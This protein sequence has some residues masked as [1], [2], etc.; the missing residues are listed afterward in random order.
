MRVDAYTKAVLTIIAACLLWM[1][2]TG[3]T[4]T[5]VAAQALRDREPQEV[6]LIGSRAPVPV[7]TPP[8][9][10]LVVRPG[11]EWYQEPLLVDAPRPLP[12]R[13]TGVERQGGRWDPLDVNVKEQP[14]KAAPGHRP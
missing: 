2:V 9:T 4:L 8:R 14:R 11:A 10:S 7:V 1:C 5:P 3:A 12:T 13:L 6:I